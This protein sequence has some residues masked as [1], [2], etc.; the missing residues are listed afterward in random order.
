MPV[1]TGVL[2]ISAPAS[3]DLGAAAPGG[4]SGAGLGVVQVTDDRDGLTGWTATVSSTDFTTGRGT[5]SETIPV[6]DVRY[7]ISGF[8]STTGSA[9]FTRTPTTSL[10]TS[11]QGV[12]TAT[13]VHGDNSVTWN[14]EIR[15]SVPSGAVGGTY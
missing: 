3:A 14:P 15:V 8:V 10:S 9:T 4:T 1:V 11:P 5:A 6:T 2:S 7:L 13:D 12:V